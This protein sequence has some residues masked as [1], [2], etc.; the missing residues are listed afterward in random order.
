M[1]Q[2][3]TTVKTHGGIIY[4]ISTTLSRLVTRYVNCSIININARLYDQRFPSKLGQ[5]YLSAVISKT[6]KMA[7]LDLDSE[8]MF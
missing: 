2:R 8:K 4:Y 7:E 3:K 5:G 1:E 6:N